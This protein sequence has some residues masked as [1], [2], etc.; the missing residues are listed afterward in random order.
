[1]ATY[2]CS[3]CGLLKELGEGEQPPR[4]CPRC[5]VTHVMGRMESV[6]PAM[7]PPPPGPSRDTG[8]GNV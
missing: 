7:Q 3:S 4:W 6:T 2:R 8:Q 1:M 5:L